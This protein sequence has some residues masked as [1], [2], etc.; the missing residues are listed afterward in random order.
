MEH[1]II[2]ENDVV[3][4]YQ[5]LTLFSLLTELHLKHFL[6]RESFRETSFSSKLVHSLAFLFSLEALQ[7][8]TMGTQYILN[9]MHGRLCGD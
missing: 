9:V 5:T 8:V 1:S 6:G 4:G 3:H 7:Q 2:F